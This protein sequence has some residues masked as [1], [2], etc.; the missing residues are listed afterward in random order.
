MSGW[1]ALSTKIVGSSYYPAIEMV[2]PQAI[3]QHA[4][5]QRVSRTG[6]PP[7]QRQT[8]ASGRGFRAV[9]NLRSAA[10]QENAGN[11]RS[12]S[13]AF[14]S[15]LAPFQDMDFGNLFRIVRQAPQCR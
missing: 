14:T 11:T 9:T 15:V 6:Q 7:S 10:R 8:S 3:H 1:S 12:H 4:R 2:M 13:L 5:R